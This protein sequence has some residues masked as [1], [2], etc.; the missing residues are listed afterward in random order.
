ME[1][2]ILHSL[3][4]ILPTCF[5]FYVFIWLYINK[6]KISALFIPIGLFIAPLL[7]H[8]YASAVGLGMDNELMRSIITL[9]F[10]NSIY[11]TPLWIVF[12]ILGAESKEDGKELELKKMREVL[13]IF[14][15][16]CSLKILVDVFMTEPFDLVL[17]SYLL[18]AFI[19]ALLIKK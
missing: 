6:G 3:L 7:V 2:Q 10:K 13:F 5:I 8:T 14:A 1:N 19:F 16:V 12:N 15:G 17:I 4:M 18:F 11:I 9:V